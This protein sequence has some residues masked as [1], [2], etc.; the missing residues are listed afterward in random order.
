MRGDLHVS[1]HDLNG[2]VIALPQQP[3]VAGTNQPGIVDLN[4]VACIGD[5]IGESRSG[6]GF[7]AYHYPNPSHTFSV[8]KR[9]TYV[10]GPGDWFVGSGRYTPDPDAAGVPLQ[11]RAG[12]VTFV[13]QARAY[14]KANEETFNDKLGPFGRTR[15]ISSPT[16]GTGPPSP[17]RSSQR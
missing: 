9:T 7:Y 10:V 6:S 13:E 15:S 11:S 16:I 1:A 3:G 5:M 8:G 17:P 4:G 12:P 14:A 2:T